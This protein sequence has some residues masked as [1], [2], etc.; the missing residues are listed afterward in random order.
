MNLRKAEVAK[1]ASDCAALIREF[2]QSISSGNMRRYE[3]IQ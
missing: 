3:K 1:V 2:N